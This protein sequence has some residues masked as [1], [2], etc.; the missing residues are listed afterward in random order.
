MKR[1]ERKMNINRKKKNLKR[2]VFTF[3]FLLIASILTIKFWAQEEIIEYTAIFNESF[4][5]TDY[6]DQTL[7]SVAHWGEGYITLQKIGGNF[8]VRNPI[9]FPTWVNTVT[10][11]DFDLDGWP[12]L[13]GSS[14]SY[15]NVLVVIRNMGGEG[16][17][18][19][20]K[21]TY[22]IDGC[23]GDQNDWPIKGVGGA[24]IDNS[25]HMWLTSADYDKDGDIDFCFMVGKEN[26][27]KIKRIW[28]YE[29]HLIDKN[30]GGGTLYFTKVDRTQA[31][32][33]KIAGIAWT[34]T[35]MQSIDYDKD[36]DIDIVT[37]TSAGLVIM[38]K[39]TN[40][41]HVNEGTFVPSQLVTIIPAW[42]LKRGVN[43]LS[44]ADFDLDGDLDIICGSVTAKEL[45]Y[46]KNDGTGN[47]KVYKQYQDNDGNLKDNEYDGAATVSLCYD[48][49]KDGDVDVVIGTDNWNYPK[50][51]GSGT[52]YGGVAYYFKNNGGEFTQR[53]IFDKRPDVYDF[54]MG[55]VFDFDMDGN[56][57]FLM[58]D[59]NDSKKYYLFVNGA[60]DVYNLQG[61]AVST[62]LTPEIDSKRQA[63]TRA[64][65]KKVDM[66][67]L[68]GSSADLGVKLYLSNNGGKNW[69]FYEEFD[70]AEIHNYS[71]LQWLTFKHFGS[72]LKW[73]AV[74]TAKADSIEDYSDAS[75]ET[76]V[77][78]EIEL[79]YV[80]VD[81]REYSR[82]SVPTVTLVD[83]KSGQKTKIIIAGTFYFPGWEG[84]LR[85]YD[86]SDMPP[87]NT[88]YSELRTIS[89]SDLSA[90]SGREILA[91]GVDIRWDAGE[92]LNSRAASNRTLYAA[93]W[94]GEEEEEEHHHHH[95]H[96]HNGLTRIEFTASNVGTLGPIL[97][98]FNGDNAGLIN[99]VRGEGRDW[100]LGDIDHSNPL[101]VGPPDED[102][103]QMGEKYAEFVKKQKNRKRVVYVGANDGMLHCFDVA[104]GEELWGF[105]PYNLLPK[106]KNMWAVDQ[107][108]GGRYFSRDVYVDGSPM[109][110]DVYIEG[111]WKTILICGQGSGKGSTI[112][113]GTNYYFAL[114]ITNPEDPK[115]LWEFTHE[116][117]GETWSVPAVGKVI[118][119]GETTW[120]AFMGS[121]YDNDPDVE[122]GNMFYAVNVDDGTDFW[123]FK[124]SDIDT[125]SKYPN[126][127]N[128]IPCSPSIIVIDQDGYADRVYVGDLDGRMWKVN[129]SVPFD[130]IEGGGTTWDSE[131][132]A[133]YEDSNNYPILS[134]PVCWANSSSGETIPHLY[135]GTGGDDRA[136]SDATYSFISLMD[137]DTPE[138]EWFV[139]DPDVLN[140]PL[141]KDKGDLDAGEKVWADPVIG[142][143]I[144]YFSTLTGSIES[145]DPSLNLAGMGKL[146]ARAIRSIGGAFTGESAFSS[147]SGAVQSLNLA[148]KAR[149]AVTLGAR[150][151][152]EEGTRK[153]EVYIQEYNSTIQKLEQPVSAVLEV[154]SWR[155]IYIVQRV[156]KIR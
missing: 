127:P 65:I 2:M 55:A 148:S 23:Q 140:L 73:R 139:G 137:G 108:T 93:Y 134:K 86:L 32:V 75:Y 63:I 126:I 110:A 103:G 151:R 59:G 31:F 44:A 47:Y 50:N 91:S 21:I 90:P 83:E 11:G 136:P 58:A 144:V 123:S 147:A 39:N 53:L 115:P 107:V 89:R 14:S 97:E 76:P 121:G 92:L 15:S 105:I 24:A 120:V 3:L 60:A 62:N 129:V 88:P 102:P 71:D 135:F 17:I 46:Y 109:A 57:D 10:A 43:T 112:E 153:R 56:M 26:D 35:M 70:G 27:Y 114:D 1:M 80:Y 150:E 22:W 4:N 33:E 130:N 19:N 156:G 138:V 7:S 25:G 13:I 141:G 36:G 84:H 18:G 145:V 149:S 12:D 118:L 152:T 45:R 132:L 128:T 79:E 52:G 113:S 106:L 119:E 51:N 9:N 87:A 74:L 8:S 125:S 48:F 101:V 143:Y 42:T 95:H 133:I 69:E 94:Q 81:K 85:A 104:T 68:G 67:A 155:E 146:Y 66:H 100:K 49:D 116:N 82:T 30:G 40:N 54:D 6:K 142:D 61:T 96:Y 78:D 20:F 98:D 37:G 77:I 154:K 99:F 122:A 34:A 64:R 29:N 28:I 41:G 131:V 117:M 72:E 124:A 16:Q 111:K 38:L 5:T